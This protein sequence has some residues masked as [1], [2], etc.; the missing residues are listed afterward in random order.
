MIDSLLSLDRDLFL[1]L[2]NLGSEPYDGFWKFITKQINW[3]PFFLVLA[4]I[5]YKDLGWKNLL[6]SLGFIGL[7]IV[8]TDQ[9]TNLV[10]HSVERLRPCSEPALEGLMR[11]VISRKSFSFFSGHA[12]NSMAAAV[13]TMQLLRPYRR[14]VFLLILWPLVFA[15]SRIYLGLHYPGDILTGYAFGAVSG[16]AFYRLY[17]W[18]LVRYFPALQNPADGQSVADRE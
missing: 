3:L 4:W 11:E 18:V 15:Y 12:C 13:F 6:L 14:F 1:F 5:V 17:R 8:F 10:K 16:L 9:M 7:M 2:N